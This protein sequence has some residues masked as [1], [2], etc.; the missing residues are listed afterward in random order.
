MLQKLKSFLEITS[1]LGVRSGLS[2]IIKRKLLN[3]NSRLASGIQF[4]VPGIRH[5]I[6]LRPGT[7]D[8]LVFLQVFVYNDYKIKLDFEPTVIIDGGANIGLATVYFKNKFPKATIIAIEPDPENAAVLKA[9]TAPY[10]DI[11]VKQA[12]LWSKKTQTRMVDKYNL[13]KWGLVTEEFTPP[14]EAGALSETNSLTVDD[15]V[16]EFN[17]AHVDVLKLD[18]ESAEKQLFMDNYREWLSKTR[19][20]IIELHDWMIEGCSKPFFSAINTV[21]HDYSFSQVGENT[22]IV[23]KDLLLVTDEIQQPVMA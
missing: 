14:D 4:T 3:S 23:N 5:P 11:H 8:V 21:F 9:N 19:V 2:F 16:H 7:S 20:V 12:S 6:H 13:G 17:L 22:I 15:I 10:D 18:I 1:A